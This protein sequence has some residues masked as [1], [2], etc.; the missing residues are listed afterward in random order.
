MSRL[1]TFLGH[2]TWGHRLVRALVHDD[3]EAKDVLQEARLAA[4]RSAPRDEARL[5]SWVG[6]VVRNLARNHVRSTRRRRAIEAAVVREA[7]ETVADPQATLVWLE[8]Q[9]TLLELLTALRPAFRDVLVL[10]Y[11]EGLTAAA[12]A[13]RL[14]VPAGTVRWRI[15][16][17]LDELRAA[18]DRRHEGRGNWVVVFAPLL[19]A[20]QPAWAVRDG[21]AAGQGGANEKV[22]KATVT[23]GLGFFSRRALLGSVVAVC[24][25]IVTA[26]SWPPG[27]SPGAVSAGGATKALPPKPSR[28]PQHAPPRLTLVLPHDNPDKDGAN[29]NHDDEPPIAPELPRWAL[30]E[31]HEP[32]RIRGVV[33]EE[34]RPLVGAAVRISPGMITFSRAFDRHAV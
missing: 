17:A 10:R 18:L 23:G 26:P 15:K 29:T 5:R 21:E 2:G 20:P 16:E 4:W 31:G 34:G 24:A 13:K 30:G 33:R 22:G 32:R 27:T 14:G 12:I 6:S 9:R 28:L 11:H 7:T 3:D 8:M 25:A 1:E 19:E